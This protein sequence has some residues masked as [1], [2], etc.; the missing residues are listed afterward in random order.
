MMHRTAQGQTKRILFPFLMVIFLLSGFLFSLE[1][2]LTRVFS[3][4]AWYHYAFIIISTA[5]LGLGL[6]GLW[7][8]R[9]LNEN[10]NDVNAISLIKLL[11]ALLLSYVSI[12]MVLYLNLFDLFPLLYMLLGL[13]PFAI[14]GAIIS[15]LFI[16]FAKHVHVLYFVDLLATGVFALLSYY[17]LNRFGMTLSLLFLF[18]VLTQ[19]LFILALVYR[20]VKNTFL[21]A[22]LLIITIVSMTLTPASL[23]QGFG[24]PL[25]SQKLKLYGVETD[26]KTTIQYTKWDSFSRTDVIDTGDEQKK[27]IFID[28]GSAAAMQKF[29]GNLSSISD[30]K[31]TPGFLPYTL[32]DKPKTLVIGPGGGKDILL[33]LL[34]ESPD[35]TAVE[36]NKS[37]I[38]AV[39]R[40]SSFSGNLYNLPQVRTYAQDGRNFIEQSKEKYDTIYLSLVMTQAAGANGLALSEN[41]IYTREAM[42]KYLEHLTDGGQ[43]VFAAHDEKDMARI[44]TTALSALERLGIPFHKAVNHIGIV[45]D[46]MTDQHGSGNNHIHYPVITIRKRPFTAGQSAQFLQNAIKNKL[47]PIYIPNKLVNAK[48]PLSQFAGIDEIILNSRPNASPT[49][50]DRPFFYNFSQ[51]LPISVTIVLFMLLYIF[52]KL[53]WPK[54]KACNQQEKAFAR[55]FFLIG[56]G[57]MAV[58]VALIQKNILL[59]G[60]PTT[61]FLATVTMMLIGSSLG[62]LA[63]KK[64][65]KHFRV[66]PVLL[67]FSIGVITFLY[68]SGMAVDTSAP[69]AAKMM[70]LAAI[71]IPLGFLMGIPFPKGI[72]RIQ[73]SGDVSFIP[74][75]WG[76]NGFASLLGSTLAIAIA[77]FFGFTGALGF[78]AMAYFLLPFLA[79][80]Q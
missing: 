66:L 27:V 7:V 44:V 29:N 11:R 60:H 21:A 35:I 54:Y 31:E 61:S 10:G 38:D 58:E 2:L 57:F 53:V 41:Y 13:I 17:V 19:I 75:M 5:I 32:Q 45:A 43:L 56:I 69:F 73:S 70:F 18:A 3:F 48:F 36:I 80:D 68:Q 40:F 28:G 39:T 74:L 33:A 30:L 64:V 67:A 4:L 22:T 50:D 20:Q 42:V 24:N 77:T 51:G 79:F 62:S 55:Y 14:G 46:L 37:S 15:I 76:I 25:A 34:A 78:G 47:E 16:H 1:F 59:F 9:Q 49:T 23:E 72:E 8:Q 6:G 63:S 12:V 71:L 65:A 26:G 52:L